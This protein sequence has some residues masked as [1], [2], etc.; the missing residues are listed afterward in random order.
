[1]RYLL[2]TNICIYLIRRKPPSVIERLSTR[3]IEDVAIS[4]ITIA[5]LQYGIY[6]SQY[7]E[8]NRTALLEFLL[9]FALLDFDQDAAR[10][11][12]ILRTQL[13]T[14]GTPIGAMDMLIAAHARSQSLIMVTNNVQEF[15][16][17]GGLTVENWS[18]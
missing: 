10:E 17:V 7:P 18:S 8:R 3:A 9:P 13:E 1:M 16:R 5:E 11:Y 2:D 4:S 14:H 12:G 15:Q 6:K